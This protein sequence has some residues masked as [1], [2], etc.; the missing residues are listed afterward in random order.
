MRQT[1]L[2]DENI[3]YHAIRRADKHD[4]PDPTAADLIDAI[5]R[6]CHLIFVN[7]MLIERYHKALKKLREN[8]PRSL[9]AMNFIKQFL[10]NNLKRILDYSEVPDLPV[11]IGV[12]TEDE[13]IV[14][15]AMITRPTIVSADSG[16]LEAVNGQ[17]ALG[18]RAMD[19][20]AAL[21]F[22]KS[23]LP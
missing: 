8:P 10:F 13:S 14:R 15:A 22:A 7:P 18:L 6:I 4:N 11:G 2:L 5:G 9:A 17:P 19:A 3:V 16:L 21:N 1:F 20:A 12:P 23:E